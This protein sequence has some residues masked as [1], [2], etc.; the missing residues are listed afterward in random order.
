MSE[1]KR[2]EEKVLQN[3][4]RLRRLV[5]ILQHPSET[6]QGFLD[7][8]LEQAI[9]L[10][11]SKIGYIYH[12]H[13]DRKEFVLNTWSKE[14]MAE[15][16]VA[17]PQT[18]YELAKT[19]IWGEAVRQRRPIVVNDFRA[20]HSLKKG[21]PEGHVQLVKFITVPIFRND[22]IVGVVGLA[23]KETD[24]EETD[25]IQASLLMETIWKVTERKRAEEALR[26]SEERHRIILRTAL[27][28]FWL[29]DTQGR[30]LEVNETY[31]RMS[32][33]SESELLAMRISDLE[34]AETTDDTA[35]HIRKIM[36][37][38]AD[39]FESKHRRKNGTIFDIE[40]S[41]QY[42]P[43][44]GGQFVVFLRDITESKRVG[45]FL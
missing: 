24:Y 37:Q 2:A 45:P 30:L 36:A 29:V 25:L 16:A 41:A 44:E 39:R 6:I 21:Y 1:R 43:S 11:G 20:A 33:Y 32:G 18:C 12:Y 42:R 9:Q 13:E 28:G 40:V 7:Y 38:G 26:E 8:A 4:S 22:S 5:D 17:N 10:T 19:G 14:V 31:C 34:S 15:C 3:E 35:T 27:D 23:N